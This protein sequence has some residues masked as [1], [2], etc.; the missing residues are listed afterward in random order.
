MEKNQLRNQFLF[1]EGSDFIFTWEQFEEALSFHD[2]RG[3]YYFVKDPTPVNLYKMMHPYVLTFGGGYLL[4]RMLDPTNPMTWS[5]YKA[6]KYDMTVKTV[7]AVGAGTVR[8]APH[9]L[10]GAAAYSTLPVKDGK[11][12]FES[13][14][15]F[16]AMSLATTVGVDLLGW[17]IGSLQFGQDQ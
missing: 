16:R 6:H 11:T 13:T 10:W 2:P 15:Q 4:T 9:I 17:D 14:S 12:D 7:R 1:E 8:A 5:A 3:P